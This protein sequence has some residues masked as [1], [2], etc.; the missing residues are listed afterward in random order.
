MLARIIA[1]GSYRRG[2]G[3]IRAS[4]RALRSLGARA[5]LVG[6]HRALAAAA[7][8]LREAMASA[9]VEPVGQVWYGGE[10][11]PENIAMVAAAIK[12]KGA[13]FLVGVGGGKALDTAKGAA[14]QAG[15]PLVTVPTIA[16]T[17]AAFTS[18][19]I[20]Y[21]QEGHFLAISHEAA[22]PSLVLVDSQIIAAAPWRY[23][24]AGMG[25]T[26]A[27]YIELRATST[28]VS[29]HL[30]LEGALGLARLC[31]D[32]ILAAGPGARAAVENQVVTP[33]LE[34][35]IDAVILISGLVSGLGGDDGRTAGAHGIY[36]GLTASPLTRGCC[37]GELVAFGNLVQLF[38]EGR[39]TKAIKHLAAFNRQV[40]LP[41]TLAEVGLSPE[42][43]PSLDL[44]SRAA[45][46][47]PDMANMPFPV[48]AA[49]I[50]EAL[51]AADRLGQELA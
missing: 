10:C 16:A 7:P 36:E 22:N 30:A 29:P 35:V 42:D 11:C 18:I 26:L 23:L 3:V 5:C 27:K 25:D 17:C 13:D 39:E 12:E 33:D 50:K 37:H 8:A 2:A 24:T 43:E 1:P 20:I 31:Y 45:A 4:G 14:W 9:G 49:M 6:G 32:S 44:I 46:E 34:R 21:D 28:A 48:T 41:I 51:L 19:A 40:G 38:L 47:S 15:V